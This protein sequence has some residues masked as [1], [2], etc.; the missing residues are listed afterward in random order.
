MALEH[1]PR[2]VTSDLILYF[3]TVNYRSYSGSGVTVNGLVSGIGFTLVNGVGFGTT[4][5]SYFIFDG[6]NDN[7]PFY[8]PNVGSIL[9][10]EMWARIKS[11]NTISSFGMPFGFAPYNVITYIGLGYNTA[12]SAQANTIYTQ[13]V[14][15]TQNTIITLAYFQANT[16]TVL[17]QAAFDK[18]NTEAL[19]IDVI[20]GINTYQNTAI[21]AT[22]NKMNA[23]YS[24]ANTV[25]IPSVTR[26]DVTNS[27]TS[28]YNFDQYSGNN[29]SIFIRSG[30]T[31]S[32]KLDVTGHPFMIRVSNGGA[33][34]DTGLTHVT[35]NGIVTT[36]LIAKDSPEGDI[37]LAPEFTLN[38][39]D[40]SATVTLADAPVTGT[41]VVIVR[42]IGKTWQTP[43]E[44][45]RYANNSIAEFI[46]EATTDLPK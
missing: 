6:T 9:S 5:T 2:I 44:Q 14:N 15:N 8:I 43:G 40:S 11:F 45:L 4:G 37:T 26:L 35:A 39:T 12:N 41:R 27:G 31:L 10:I 33:N 24:Q 20:T 17:A 32:F 34:Y 38:I 16:G 42:K 19:D 28:G 13:G 25:Y 18:A 30:E 21:Y 3:D 46:R 22:D 29:P 23:A 36:E 1:H 7:I